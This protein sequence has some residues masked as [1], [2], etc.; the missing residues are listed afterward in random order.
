[1]LA[2]FLKIFAP[3]ILILP[4]ITAAYLTLGAEDPDMVSA[5]TRDGAT[6]SNLAYGAL[7]SRVLPKWLLGFF[8]AVIVGSILSTFNSVL[9]SSA[10]LFSLD[11]YKKHLDPNATTQR[12]VRVG[13]ICSFAV[14]VFAVI[15]AP[16]IFHGQQG[17]FDFFQGLNGV[18]FTPLCAIML[19]AM[20]NNRVNGTSALISIAVGLVLMSLGTFATGEGDANWVKGY[21]GSPF[22]YM[23]AVLVFLVLLQLGLG[24]FCGM[25][26]ET[27]YVQQNVEAVDITPWKPAPWVGGALVAMVVAIYIWFAQ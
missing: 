17:V 8:A 12:V 9:N 4:G 1:M 16:L 23:G 21:F 20:F 27:P 10:T 22:H 7:V 11:V 25:E 24:K 6:D 3:V 2:A 18:Y 13:Q 5:M 14:A 19:L 15:A 26:R